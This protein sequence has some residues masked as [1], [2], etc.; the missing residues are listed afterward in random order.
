[1]YGNHTLTQSSLHTLRYRYALAVALPLRPP[2]EKVAYRERLPRAR[3]GPRPLEWIKYS[4][5][6]NGE[7]MVSSP[8]STAFIFFFFT[9][10]CWPDPG[11]IRRGGP[12]LVLAGTFF[13]YSDHFSYSLYILYIP[14]VRVDIECIHEIMVRACFTSRD[15]TWHRVSV[16]SG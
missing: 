11:G 14:A 12:R 8:Y 2:G 4:K 10:A 16:T 5:A 1:M 3:L 15:E 7:Q 9:A 13:A 6:L